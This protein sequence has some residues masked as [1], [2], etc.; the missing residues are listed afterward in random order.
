MFDKFFLGYL[1]GITMATA[2][3]IARIAHASWWE[4]ILLIVVIFVPFRIIADGMKN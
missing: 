4:D 3:T 2:V 1:C